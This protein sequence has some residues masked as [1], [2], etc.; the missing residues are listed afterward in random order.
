MKKSI[1]IVFII[2]LSLNGNSQ[3][4]IYH[5]LP[6]ENAVWRESFGGSYTSS[7]S[8]YQLIII[9]DTLFD[10]F[11]YHKIQKS[12]VEYYVDQSGWC[13]WI[14]A[15]H[16]DYYLG[17]FRND[18]VNKMVYFL[19]N[20]I[21]TLLYNFNLN[22][23]DTLPITYTNSYS[24]NYVETIDSILIGNNFHKRYGIASFYDPGY[25][26]VHLIEGIGSTFGF[27]ALFNNHL[28]LAQI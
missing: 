15:Y 18:S 4:H 14:I 23:G 27:L 10:G 20:S 17:A 6:S 2:S 1:L 13:T 16:F 3:F 8:D 7:C 24:D 9:G 26:Y 21:D 19:E 5:P 11:T 12:G 25:V 28:N 22:V